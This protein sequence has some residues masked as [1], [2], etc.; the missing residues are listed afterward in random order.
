MLIQ[1]SPEHERLPFEEGFKRSDKPLTISDILAVV[2]KVE[3][4]S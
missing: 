4:V 3:A 1:V 2:K